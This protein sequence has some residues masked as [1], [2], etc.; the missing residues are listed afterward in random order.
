MLKS[1]LKKVL[2]ELMQLN[3]FWKHAMQA[4]ILVYTGLPDFTKG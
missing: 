2:E 1:V 4:E 3:I